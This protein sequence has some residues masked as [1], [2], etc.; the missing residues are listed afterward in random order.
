MVKCDHG[1]KKVFLKSVKK[2]KN[3][4]HKSKIIVIVKCAYVFQGQILANMKA[5]DSDFFGKTYMGMSGKVCEMTK[6][7]D[8]S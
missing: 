7:Y 2:I 5:L 3:K 6:T 1:M 4:V 8:V